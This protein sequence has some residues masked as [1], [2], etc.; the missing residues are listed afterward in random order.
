MTEQQ[1]LQEE[2][3]SYELAIVKLEEAKEEAVLKLEE[4]IKNKEE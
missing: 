4:I 1:K 3:A 2:I